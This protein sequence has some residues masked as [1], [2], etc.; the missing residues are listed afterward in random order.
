MLAKRTADGIPSLIAWGLHF[1]NKSM[2]GW[3]KRVDREI[4][5]W[6]STPA[7]ILG[8]R[9]ESEIGNYFEEIYQW[10]NRSGPL[11]KRSGFRIMEVF[12]LYFGY[13]V[14]WWNEAN[15]DPASKLP[16]TMKCLEEHFNGKESDFSR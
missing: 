12:D 2:S 16:K 8:L 5:V 13:E 4:A 6:A 3:K 15:D 7:I 14:P 9:F 1:A 10:H 11:H